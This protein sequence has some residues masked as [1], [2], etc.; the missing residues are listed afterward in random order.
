VRSIVAAVSVVGLLAFVAAGQTLSPGEIRIH[1]QPYLPQSQILRA[2]SGLVRVGVVV[3]DGRRRIVSGL[4]PEDFAIFDNG[5]KQTISA[6]SVET[7]APSDGGEV[8]QSS[9]SP[10]ASEQPQSTPTSPG[11]N[12]A[13]RPTPRFVALYFDDLHTKS[14]D[15]KHVQVAAENFVHKGLTANDQVALFTA[16]SSASVGFTAD[17]SKVLDALAKLKSHERVFDGGTCP[18][19]TPHD[20]YLIAN[21][22]DPDAYNTALAAAKECNC[23]DQVNI[24]DTCYTQQERVV[25]VEAQQLWEPIRELSETTLETIQGVLHY[26][27]KTPGDRVLVL[28]SPGFFTSSLNTQV[29]TIVDEA[30]RAGIVIN[31][32]DA[33]GLYTEDPTHGR[34]LNESQAGRPASV[35]QARHEGESFAPDLMSLTGA[36][37]DFALGTGGSFFHDRNDLTAGY[38]SLAATPET[39]YL[40]GFEPEKSKL[41]GTFHRLKVQVNTPGT[42]DVQ[43]RPGYFTPTKQVSVEPTLDEK[44]D[45]EV[46]GSEERSDFPVSVSEKPGTAS[47]GGRE[48]SVET[49]VDIQKLPFQRQK[50]QYVDKLRIVAALFDAQGRMIAGKE[51]QMELALKQESFERFSKSGIN[52]VM[53]VE[54][55]PGA[56]RLR[57]VA[58]EAIQGQMSAISQNVQIQ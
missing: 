2:E 16:S 50:D 55:P 52:G 32:L 37:A 43:A 31:A 57:V 30:L 48:I 47:N 17:A 53:S 5:K 4:K 12:D 25:L 10:L 27:A 9:P 36:M 34:M 23:D 14:G 15:M 41:N 26:L 1:S 20:A 22:L 35:M 13:A 3:R 7:H 51:A 56:Y 11:P 49:R 45:A 54:A 58:Q 28:A 8:Q 6:F 19:I 18:R 40:I 46:R 39:E 29:D 21:H 24:D 42:F 33:K 44:I 38:Y